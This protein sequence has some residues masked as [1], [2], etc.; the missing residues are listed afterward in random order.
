MVSLDELWD[1]LEPFLKDHFYGGGLR[2]IAAKLGI[3]VNDVP[4]LNTK[5]PLVAEI[6]RRLMALDEV[7]RHAALIRLPGVLMATEGVN[8]S[9]L[10]AHLDEA[11]ERL[12][13]VVDEAGVIVLPRPSREA[14]A[15]DVTVERSS[16]VRHPWSLDLADFRV[17]ERVS[18]APEG[19]TL[20][21]GPNGAGKT[22]L[23][24][25]LV[26]LRVL[27][28]RGHVAALSEIGAGHLRRMGAA[29]STPVRLVLSVGDVRW[30]LALPV[31]ARGLTSYYGEELRQ[32]DAVAL[33][34]E[35]L[36]E[37][38]TLDG[39]ARSHEDEE[40][41][42]A[43]VYWDELGRP[44]WMRPLAALLQSVRVYK[45][46]DLQLV[47]DASRRN[48][49]DDAL[50]PDGSNLWH[51]LAKWHGS[52]RRFAGAYAWVLRHARRAF[53]E[54]LQDLEF[55][56]YIQI[57]SP[58]SPGADAG[59]PPD[60]AADGLLTG[61]LQLT[62]VAGAKPGA[63]L[64]FDE[65]ENQLHPHAIRQIITAMR[66][67]AAERDLTIVLTTHS[68]VVMNEFNEVPG[69][70]HVVERGMSPAPRR[71]DELKDP[72]WLAMFALGDLYERSRFAAPEVGTG[73]E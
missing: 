51:V 47:R 57:F 73:E 13:L 39:E 67:R 34:A 71:L 23:L 50:K 33:R 32:G 45:S 63:V 30:E 26:F 53:P 10:K 11:I 52:P 70:V 29:R 3:P 64:A 20:L 56:P 36:K 5:A 49:L 38:W 59:L 43:R 46:W 25:A 68:P 65:V 21:A 58:D 41:T 14:V 66:E 40:R 6:R 19:V 42:C 15:G 72:S 44:D 22:S 62:A 54:L 55:E 7:Q 61:L 27:F 35:M 37:T 4:E 2:Q 24:D 1:S 69:Q 48:D 28:L 17:F 18:W 8:P 16:D 31:N 9:R 60:R 12:G